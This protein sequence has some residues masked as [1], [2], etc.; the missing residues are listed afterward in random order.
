MMRWLDQ[1]DANTKFFNNSLK[2]NLSKN[3]IIYLKSYSAKCYGRIY[4]L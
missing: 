4:L 1:G 3:A 2:A